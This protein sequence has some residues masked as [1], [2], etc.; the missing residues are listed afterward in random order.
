[1]SLIRGCT[2]L[3]SLI[4]PDSV[5]RIGDAAFTNCTLLSSLYIPDSVT[6]IG[7]GISDDSPALISLHIPASVTEMAHYTFCRSA[8]GLVLTVGRGSYA[9]S[10]A[11]EKGLPFICRAG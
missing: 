2:S 1:M 6:Y 8:P 3:T 10:C 9:E 7:P 4:V 5:T 11:L